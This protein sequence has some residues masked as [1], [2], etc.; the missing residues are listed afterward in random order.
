MK[1]E[2]AASE[3]P[4]LLIRKRG[5]AI[6]CALEAD[7]CRL[8]VSLKTMK[9]ERSSAKKSSRAQSGWSRYLFGLG[10]G[11]GVRVRVRR[12]GS[13]AKSGR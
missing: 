6:R 2:V 10:S 5:E 13:R 12:N 8:A 11:L 9:R 7:L 3:Q 1:L 4:A